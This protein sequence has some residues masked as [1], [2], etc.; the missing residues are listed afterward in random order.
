[1]EF[2]RFLRAGQAEAEK[3]G[4][5]LKAAA[6]KKRRASRVENLAH[7]P[8]EEVVIEPE[9]KTCPCCGGELHVIGEDTSKRLDKL[10]AKVRVIVTRRPK[11]ACRS[12]EKTGADDMAGVIQVA[13]PRR[14]IEGGLPTEAFVADVVV[15]K[16]AD[17]QRFIADRRPSRDMASRSSA[18]R[19]RSGSVRPRPSW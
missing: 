9:S 4:A 8:H 5:T 14:L 17:H 18:R 3:A 6:A 12:C 11:Y 16:Y 15:A 19:W 10:P 2:P 7:L 1:M 13:A